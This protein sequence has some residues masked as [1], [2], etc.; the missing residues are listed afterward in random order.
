MIIIDEYKFKLGSFREG[1]DNLYEALKIEDVKAQL[2][3]D[4]ALSATEGFWNDME[5]SQ[6]VSQAIKNSKNIIAEYESLKTQ[7]EDLETLI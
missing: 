1:L 3:K 4:E 7:C 5:L 6:K 2:E